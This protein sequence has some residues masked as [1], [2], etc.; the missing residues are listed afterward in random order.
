MARRDRT[1][2]LPRPRPRA[3]A[4]QKGLSLSDSQQ[5]RLVWIIGGLVIA[6]IVAFWGWRWYDANYVQPNKTILQVGDEKF[7]L[8]YY[9]DRL[10]LAAQ[11]QTGGGAN[12][13]ILQ[14]TLLTDLENEAI[15]RI[16]AKERGITVS[17]EE[18]T[19]EIAAQL[20]VPAGGAGSSFDT[21]Y[22]QRLRAVN[23]SDSYYRRLTR[24][25][26]YV[27]KLGDQLKADLGDTGEM[28]T[29]RK[30]VAANEADAKA[31]LDRVNGGED[32]GTVA[33][34]V[35]TDLN[36]RQKDGLDDPTP[37]RLLP[38]AVRTAI[39]GK[40]SNS[41]V[42]GPLQVAGNWWVF[43]VETRDPNGTYSETNKSQLGQFALADA[44]RDKRPQV[45]ITRKMDSSDFE[46]AN[47]HAAD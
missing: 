4:K 14:Q 47:E 42:L 22:R 37:T 9:A 30:V 28:I 13:S 26:V 19:N 36:S 24:A 17:E 10:Y 41:E 32:L 29:I 44:I 6:A 8:K 12:L 20:G 33:Q 3:Q 34:T 11:A 27:T 21:L 15:V 45:T 18:V 39:E 7:P 35:S 40:P 43:R 16:L 2:A 38:D 25:Q 46:W 1:T 31:A 5:L 23:M